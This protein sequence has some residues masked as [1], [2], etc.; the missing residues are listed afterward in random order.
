[1]KRLIVIL[2]ILFLFRCED[3]KKIEERKAE[4]LLKEAEIMVK[5]CNYDTK[6]FEGLK[7]FSSIIKKFPDRNWTL[8]AVEKFIKLT[9]D[10]IIFSKLFEDEKISNQ[11][12][13]I[14]EL[15]PGKESDIPKKILDYEFRLIENLIQN[16]GKNN[17]LI[18]MKKL[19]HALRDSCK[20]NDINDILKDKSELSKS[21]SLYITALIDYLF[22]NLNMMDKKN[23][24]T[25]INTIYRCINVRDVQMDNRKILELYKLMNNFAHSFIK[26]EEPFFKEYVRRLK[27]KFSNFKSP[28]HYDYAPQGGI[29]G[30]KPPLSLREFGLSISPDNLWIYNREKKLYI[31]KRPSIHIKNFDNF[32]IYDEEVQKIVDYSEELT[33]DDILEAIKLHIQ[34]EEFTKRAFFLFYRECPVKEVKNV[35]EPV[36]AAGVDEIFFG[37]WAEKE[38][39][40]I[41]LPFG[42]TPPETGF[43]TLRGERV[44]Y[45]S[46]DVRYKLEINPSGYSF[47][48]EKSMKKT[49]IKKEDENLNLYN[50]YNELVRSLKENKDEGRRLEIFPSL[51]EEFYL[52]SNIIETSYFFLEK[53]VYSSENEFFEANVKYR[54]DENKPDFMFEKISIIFP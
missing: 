22:T 49:S 18:L 5:G 33:N 21:A 45:K 12:G 41:F 51:G 52:L 17:K 43:L 53:E 29:A 42:V 16:I 35:L 4:K 25:Q 31:K 47:F 40:I 1:M 10:G 32:E 39:D 6:C 50:L 8:I 36:I 14:L 23:I 7:S 48:R 28:L 44:I 46:S 37:E 13:G 2:F 9:I 3:K 26:E 19:L 54:T 34:G 15:Y 11:I 30:V 38:K 20:N 27:A 24:F